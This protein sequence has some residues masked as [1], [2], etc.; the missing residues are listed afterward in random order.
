M[1]SV[2][3]GAS[4]LWHH[5]EV[6]MPLI[7]IP[8]RWNSRRF[9]LGTVSSWEVRWRHH[10]FDFCISFCR[11]Y[12]DKDCW[13]QSKKVPMFGETHPFIHSS[14]HPFIHSSIHW[15]IHP[16]IYSIICYLYDCLILFIYLLSKLISVSSESIYNECTSEHGIVNLFSANFIHYSMRSSFQESFS[17]MRRSQRDEVLCIAT[18]PNVLLD[19]SPGFRSCLQIMIHLF[20]CIKQIS[21]VMEHDLKAL[22]R[23]RERERRGKIQDITKQ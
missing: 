4:S 3:S 20:R 1:I 5:F 19:N 14:I 23:E 10:H 8:N 21:W 22:Q 15:S 11:W 17:P 6:K 13:V 18:T 12:E 7:I 16:S 9:S 2:A